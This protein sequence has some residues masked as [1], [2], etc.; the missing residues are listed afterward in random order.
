MTVTLEDNQHL[1]QS[2]TCNKLPIPV[3]NNAAISGKQFIPI[4][5][6][7]QSNDLHLNEIDS[8][9]IEVESGNISVL[10]DDPSTP[11]FTESRPYT[12]VDNTQ[13][14]PDPIGNVSAAFNSELIPELNTSAAQNHAHASHSP[15]VSTAASKPRWTRVCRAPP[16]P[17]AAA[18][19]STLN[20]GKRPL[21]LIDDQSKLPNK[22]CMVSRSD[23]D[24]SEKL[25]E[26]VIQPCQSP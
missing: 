8:A 9:L 3:Q 17:S 12:P 10:I 7:P 23:E 20:Y 26:A 4:P 11:L 24:A 2:V 18:S 16:Q 5:L 14:V 21:T 1:R 15:R 6:N 19:Q 25:A 22:R 13:T